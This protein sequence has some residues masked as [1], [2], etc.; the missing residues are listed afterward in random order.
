MTSLMRRMWKLYKKKASLSKKELECFNCGECG[1]F[2]KERPHSKPKK[3]N[4]KHQEENDEDEKE[5][6]EP[7]PHFKK[8]STKDKTIKG[9]DKRMKTKSVLHQPPQVT[10]LSPPCA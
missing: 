8:F 10:P 2:A 3:N 6:L 7:K 1:H 9:K 5:E 4:S